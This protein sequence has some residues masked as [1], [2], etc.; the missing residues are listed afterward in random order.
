M[1]APAY[2]STRQGA[3][4]FVST[5]NGVTVRETPP[6]LVSTQPALNAVLQDAAKHG[7]PLDVS[8]AA[9]GV[10]KLGH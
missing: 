10:P 3:G 9:A 2:L 6:V 8:S 1:T 5:Q 4:T 7:I